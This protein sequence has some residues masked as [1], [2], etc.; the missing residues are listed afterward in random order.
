[1]V[2]NFLTKGPGSSLSARVLQPIPD[3]LN[4]ALDYDA[5]RLLGIAVF[6]FLIGLSIH[7]RRKGQS[8]GRKRLLVRIASRPIVSGGL[9][10][11]P[12]RG[13]MRRL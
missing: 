6:W 7:R 11:F 8:L 10:G 13:C 5:N 12:T 4:R 9:Y 2:T 1:M 3:T